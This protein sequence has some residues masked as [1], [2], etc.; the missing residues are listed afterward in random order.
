MGQQHD[1]RLLLLPLSVTSPGGAVTAGIRPLLLPALL[2]RRLGAST[3]A[4]AT[5]VRLMDLQSPGR[6]SGE[7]LQQMKKG[8]CCWKKPQ[9]RMGQELRP[10]SCKLLWLGA[11]SSHNP[12][13]YP[14]NTVRDR[15]L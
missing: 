4:C 12:G 10:R 14:E 7:E 3:G 8:A 15:P 11:G 9:I 6:L 1:H 2:K 13:L 5:Q